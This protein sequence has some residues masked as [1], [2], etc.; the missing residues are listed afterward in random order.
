MPQLQH[1]VLTP[2]QMTIEL[3][4][5][6]HLSSKKPFWHCAV[7]TTL[8]M[9][10]VTTLLAELKA[11][12][13][14]LEARNMDEKLATGLTQQATYKLS[15]MNGLTSPDAVMLLNHIKP[16]KLPTNMKDA[17]IKE[18]DKLMVNANGNIACKVTTAAS[19]CD[20]LNKYLTKEDWSQ[21]ESTNSW[22]GA[23]V[24]A[25]RL[26]SMGV[27]SIKE[28]TKRAAIAILLCIQQQQ[29]CKKLPPYHAIYNLVEHL[30]QA[31]ANRPG[32]PYS[33]PCLQ[34][35][36]EDP[37]SLG[38]EVLQLVYQDKKPEARYF[39]QMAL[40]MAHH[41]PVRCTSKLLQGANRTTLVQPATHGNA[42]T[43][44]LQP[45][46]FPLNL[47]QWINQQGH[48]ELSYWS[49]PCNSQAL[50]L[51][52]NAPECQQV[53]SQGAQ[54]PNGQALSLQSKQA[55]SQS[56]QAT[57][58]VAA[59][60]EAIVPVQAPDNLNQEAAKNKNGKATK[61]LDQWN[62]Q[63]FNAMLEKQQPQKMKRPAAAKAAKV[64][65]A[66][67]ANKEKKPNAKANATSKG[68][69]PYGCTR[70][71]GNLKGCATCR[72]PGFK[73]LKVHGREA[74]YRMCPNAK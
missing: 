60:S 47:H 24:L 44:A 70:C 27:K 16:S 15:K 53:P 52:C 5:L 56:Q 1:T 7:C 74:W 65:K 13:Q 10:S 31:V 41:I 46:A 4:K 34:V 62:Q 33:V 29:G 67:G 71:R 48:Q 55:A 28:T 23:I 6:Q 57:P 20:H 51:Q 12:E 32:A 14:L 58:Q 3:M 40:T 59:P 72:K 68:K 25:K 8:A 50:P 63:A 26:K 49:Q 35:Y 39:D 64:T 37:Q 66:K 21:L 45:N 43:H 42:P 11:N 18:V 19:A 61:T 22:E 9:F 36:P 2:L 17:I 69:G 38:Q 30:S 54:H 73:G